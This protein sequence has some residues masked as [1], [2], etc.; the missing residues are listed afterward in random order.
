[1]SRTV[2]LGKNMRSFVPPVVLLLSLPSYLYSQTAAPAS[3]P[4]GY[5]WSAQLSK[6]PALAFNSRQIYGASNAEGLY[7]YL[8]QTVGDNWCVSSCTGYATVHQ[9]AGATVA[10]RFSSVV[11]DQSCGWLVWRRGPYVDGTLDP[12]RG[13][14]KVGGPQDAGAWPTVSM[15][16]VTHHGG[17]FRRYWT[18]GWLYSEATN[19]SKDGPHGQF[20]QRTQAIGPVHLDGTR[21]ALPDPPDFAPDLTLLSAVPNTRGW[22]GFCWVD[23]F[24][25]ESQLSD[26]VTCPPI[27]G[28]KSTCV[29]LG[30]P[31]QPPHG[32]CSVHLYYGTDPHSLRRV[33]VLSRIG[34]LDQYEWPLHLTRYYVHQFRAD[35]PAPQP[36][37]I[38]QSWLNPIQFGIQ[39]DQMII[40]KPGTWQLYCPLL[41]SYDPQHF[42]RIIG[43]Q[44]A[45]LKLV[46]AGAFP[47]PT[48]IILNQRDRLM[49]LDVVATTACAAIASSDFSGGQAFSNELIGCTFQN[50]TRDGYGLL[51]DEQ[52]SV[53]WGNHTASELLVHHCT[54]SA[55]RPIKLEG[56]QT[57]KFRFNDRTTINCTGPTRYPNEVCAIEAFTPNTV[58]FDAIEGVNGLNNFRTFVGLYSTE[59]A[60]TVYISDVFIDHGCSVICAYGPNTGGVVEFTRGDKIGIYGADRTWF[61]LAECPNSVSARLKSRGLQFS[62]TG[63]ILAYN[64]NSFLA[65]LD[66]PI[67]EVVSPSQEEW[68]ARGLPLQFAGKDWT[69]P[70]LRTWSYGMND[71]TDSIP[72]TSVLGIGSARP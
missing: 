64:L 16:I 42:G 43:D 45:R 55:A 28:T 56:R 41:L 50:K 27:A 26:L 19:F 7:D 33:P 48:I 4:T 68:T 58:S 10:V 36:S 61:R 13:P 22:A 14:W 59:G 47:S 62:E 54:F 69:K 2:V 63:S 5:V 23:Q 3:P 11:L 8:I 25:R 65:D 46:Q 6:P 12:N 38:C 24:G 18:N 35:S 49:N 20:Y 70:A 29:E 9:P 57:A 71:G 15:P 52:S 31:C 72:R 30:R 44:H 60:P 66:R 39:T 21:R 17:D 34:S 32:A 53:T 1:M 51:V 67:K 37:A 40:N